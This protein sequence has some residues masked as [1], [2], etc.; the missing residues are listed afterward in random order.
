MGKGAQDDTIDIIKTG[1]GSITPF[2]S[3]KDAIPWGI[4]SAAQVWGGQLWFAVPVTAKLPNDYNA[5]AWYASWVSWQQ[6]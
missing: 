3:V 1:S 4:G 5:S 6:L 2:T